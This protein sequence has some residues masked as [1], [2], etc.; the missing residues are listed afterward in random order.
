MNRFFKLE[1]DKGK[2]VKMLIWG[3]GIVAVCSATLLFVHAV[4]TRTI[5]APDFSDWGNNDVVYDSSDANI[6]NEQTND[7][8]GR[9]LEEDSR[10][11]KKREQQV[12]FANWLETDL[13]WRRYNIEGYDLV[14][15]SYWFKSGQYMV[16]RAVISSDYDKD[17]EDYEQ[18]GPYKYSIKGN[19][20]Y[21]DDN[22][23][24]E[25]DM[26]RNYIVIGGEKYYRGDDAAMS[27]FKKEL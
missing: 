11:E 4:T 23:F 17:F 20:V 15:Y 9:K 13:L 18:H 25:I 8:Q 16:S 1:D 10:M 12:E 5:T 3:I 27:A 22:V 2:K 6:E 26:S 21:N 24:F 19:T 14:L 7:K